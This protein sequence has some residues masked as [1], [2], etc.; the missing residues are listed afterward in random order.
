MEM[1]LGHALRPLQLAFKQNGEV[2]S[3]HGDFNFQWLEPEEPVRAFSRALH[4]VLSCMS[5]LG[6]TLVSTHV[7]CRSLTGTDGMVLLHRME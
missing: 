6:L 3:A 4:V 7:F 1:L 2:L 5:F